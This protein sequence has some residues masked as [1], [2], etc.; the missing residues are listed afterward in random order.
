MK[1][2][3]IVPANINYRIE[4]IEL[5]MDLERFDEAKTGKLKPN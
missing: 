2:I 4:L 3:E 1:A 5:F